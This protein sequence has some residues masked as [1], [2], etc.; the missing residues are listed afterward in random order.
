MHFPVD[1]RT[2]LAAFATVWQSGGVAPYIVFLFGLILGSFLSVCIV[3]IPRRESIVT[4]PS[5]CPHCG[6]HIRPI[7]NIPLLSYLKLRGRCRKCGERISLIYPMVEL[8]TALL[9]LAC[10]LSFGLSPLFIKWLAFCA[11]NIVLI[12]TDLR[13]RILPDAVNCAG[14][15]AG[16]GASLFVSVPSAVRDPF[17]HSLAGA[18]FRTRAVSLEGAL[19]GA[20]CGGGV[21]WL[22]AEG[23][24]RLRHKEGMGLGDVKMMLM[25]GSF[26]GWKGALLTILCG[27]VM[28]SLIGLGFMAAG[29]RG[30][31]YQWPFGS[32][33]GIAAIAVAFWGP[34]FIAWYVFLY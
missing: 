33:L 17:F 9:A 1:D 2:W 27:S 23:Y 3:R 13:E 25:A 31:D 30:R 22:F 14:L 7:D 21:L 6:A 26:L 18:S 5:H 4:P 29:R 24:F 32:F 10:Y 12:F 20:A 16:L 34:R 15:V 28:G 11:L 19:L 8:L